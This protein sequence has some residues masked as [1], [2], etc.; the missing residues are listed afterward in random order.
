VPLEICDI[1][2]GS[3]YIFDRKVVFYREEKY[4]IFSRMGLNILSELIT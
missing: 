4:I 3:P 2:L 1:V